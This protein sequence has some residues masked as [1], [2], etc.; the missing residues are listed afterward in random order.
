MT[1]V[2]MTLIN[3]TKTSGTQLAAK[4][5]LKKYR[6]LARRKPYQRPS[7]SVA[8]TEFD[9]LE[10]VDYNNDTSISDLSD[11]V[12]GTRKNIN[13]QKLLKKSYRNTKKLLKIKK[14]KVKK[15]LSSTILKQ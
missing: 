14:I 7:D 6:N 8:T 3:L 4:K 9:D 2:L 13:A 12:S 15:K 5:I 1:Q 11:I 10:T